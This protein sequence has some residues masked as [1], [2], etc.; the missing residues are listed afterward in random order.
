MPRRPK[1]PMTW[2]TIGACSG[3][4]R[5]WR[6]SSR[7]CCYR[8]KARSTLI[9]PKPTPSRSKV[10]GGLLFRTRAPSIEGIR[11]ADGPKPVPESAWITIAEAGADDWANWSPDGKTMYFTS[12]RD[13]HNCLWGQRIEASSRRLAGEPFAVQHFHGRVSFQQQGGWSA[14]GGR[15]G[16][17]TRRGYG[18]H[19]DNVTLRGALTW[20]GRGATPVIR[21]NPGPGPQFPE[22]SPSTDNVSTPTDLP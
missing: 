16:T 9:P 19:L 6:W 8:T 4:A 17:G 5:R 20:D 14:A 11:G 3:A 2:G 21:G 18:Q 7:R 1:K 22:Q 15:I 12:R 10:K 13:G